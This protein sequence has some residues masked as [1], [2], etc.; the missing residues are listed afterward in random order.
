MADLSTSDK[1]VLG[2][3]GIETI[4]FFI[5]YWWV[6]FYKCDWENELPKQP[7]T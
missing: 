4:I 3:Y 7:G 2:F 1:W 6:Y 5:V